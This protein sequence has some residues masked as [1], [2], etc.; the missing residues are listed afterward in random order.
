[1]IDGKFNIKGGSEARDRSQLE[2]IRDITQLDCN[3]GHHI[4]LATR[5]R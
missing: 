1:M 5:G 3:A 4:H 2:M